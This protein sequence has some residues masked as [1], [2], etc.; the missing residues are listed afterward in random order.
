MG[1]RYENSARPSPLLIPYQ[2]VALLPRVY[3]SSATFGVLGDTSR[4]VALPK[5]YDDEEHQRFEKV[6]QSMR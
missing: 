4:S 6:K 5:V 3:A 2:S 1:H